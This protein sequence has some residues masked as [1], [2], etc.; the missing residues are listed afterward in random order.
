M[1]NHRQVTLVSNSKPSIMSAIPACSFSW[2]IRNVLGHFR[3]F[4][5][6]VGTYEST[7]TPNIREDRTKGHGRVRLSVREVAQT[8][9]INQNINLFNLVMSR[10]WCSFGLL[11]GPFRFTSSVNE[12]EKIG[13]WSSVHWLW[14]RHIC[15]VY[16]AC[17]MDL[18]SLILK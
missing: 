2:K 1:I 7:F 18:F 11:V 8:R 5:V 6:Q 12:H 3:W 4:V 14:W 13:G 10:I 15:E 9:D 17:E 16:L